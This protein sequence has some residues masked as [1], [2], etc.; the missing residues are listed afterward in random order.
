MLQQ[1]GLL[2]R[3]RLTTIG[4]SASEIT[5]IINLNSCLT[6]IVGAFACVI[7]IN[8]TMFFVLIFM[9]KKN[10]RERPQIPS[11]PEGSTKIGHK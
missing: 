11:I 10:H 5:T 1:F 7:I 2:F 4:L 9:Q 3:D 8:H 6:S